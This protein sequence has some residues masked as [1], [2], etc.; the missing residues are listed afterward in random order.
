MTKKSL[1][2]F[3]LAACLMLGCTACGAGSSQPASSAAPTATPAPTST[4][5][6]DTFKEAAQYD[7]KNFTDSQ[8]ITEAGLWEGV[9][10]LDYV[11]LPENYNAIPATSADLAPTEA[12]LKAGLDSIVAQYEPAAMGDTVNIDYI[13]TVD[14]VEFVGGNTNGA[15]YDLTLGS[16]AFIDGFE[17]QV[18]GHKVGEQFAINVTFPKGYD[19]TTDAAGNTIVM[20]ETEAVFHITVNSISYGWALTDDWVKTNLADSGYDVSTVEHLKNYVS[21]NLAQD[22]R[23]SF[24]VYYLMTNSTFG[25]TVPEPVLD[26]MTCKYLY[27]LNQYADYYGEELEDFLLARGFNSIDEVLAYNEDSIVMAVQEQLV[28][29]AVAEAMGLQ[30]DTAAAAKYDSYVESYGQPYVNQYALCRQVVDTV[31]NNMVIG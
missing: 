29:Q 28:Y 23:E 25:E 3:S 13:G 1:I 18:A 12:Q 9:T 8:G 4:V 19:A 27:A 5:V 20:S 7:Y 14:G 22:N 10:A 11:T 30:L 31:V 26:Y 15:G 2:S 6:S 16:G 24:A 21:S 17:E